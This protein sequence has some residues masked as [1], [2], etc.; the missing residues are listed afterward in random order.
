MRLRQ[1]LQ[2]FRADRR[3]PMAAAIAAKTANAAGSGTP[4]APPLPGEVRPKFV[5]HVL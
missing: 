3:H 5:R 2:R 1:P 4:L